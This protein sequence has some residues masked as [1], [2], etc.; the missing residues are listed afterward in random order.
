MATDIRTIQS[1]VVVAQD[2]LAEAETSMPKFGHPFLAKDFTEHQLYAIQML[3]RFLRTDTQG[4]IEKLAD[5]AEVCEALGL[6]AVPD[7][8]TLFQA[9]ARLTR[10]GF[11]EEF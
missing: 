10:K 11:L 8:A 6:D 1:L 3:R 5:S 9:D 4:V 2:A 7:Y